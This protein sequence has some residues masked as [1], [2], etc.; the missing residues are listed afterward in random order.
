VHPIELL[1]DVGHVE[2]HLGL[3]GGS[4]NLVVLLRDMGQV[5]T[6]FSPLG[7]NI[8]LDAR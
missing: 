6:H 1:S 3:F 7:D 5:E 8:N 2:A 4:V